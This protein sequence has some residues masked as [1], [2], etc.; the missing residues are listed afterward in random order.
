MS[1]KDWKRLKG[2]ANLKKS[3]LDGQATGRSTEKLFMLI[4]FRDLDRNQ[5]QDFAA[6]HEAGLLP[7]LFNILHEY[8]KLTIPEAQ[9]KRFKIYGNFPKT[10][11]FKHPSF[12][13]EDAKWASLHIQGEEVI[14]GHMVNHVFYIVFLDQHHKFYPSKLKHT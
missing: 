8:T 1:S 3:I 14:A 2:Q 5:G 12:V 7:K 10:S 9:S 6:W 13:T 11:E 4:S